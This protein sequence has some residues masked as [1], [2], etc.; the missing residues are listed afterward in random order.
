M[1]RTFPSDVLKV[2]LREVDVTDEWDICHYLTRLKIEERLKIQRNVPSVQR[3]IN[4]AGITTHPK[5]NDNEV[6]GVLSELEI[7]VDHF[8][9]NTLV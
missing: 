1:A 7:R 8:C 6:K 2:G 9:D 3:P 5:E 4:R